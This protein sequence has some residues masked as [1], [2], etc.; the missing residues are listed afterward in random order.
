[1]VKNGGQNGPEIEKLPFWTNCL[2]DQ[3]FKNYISAQL[4]TKKKPFSYVVCRDY[5]HHP[6]KMILV[7]AFALC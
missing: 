2:E 4:N 6:L 5:S 3:L 1:M 7:F